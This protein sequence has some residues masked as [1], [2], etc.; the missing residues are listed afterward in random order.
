VTVRDYVLDRLALLLAFFVALAF[1]LLV[2]HLGVRPLRI[3]EVGY[4]ALLAVVAAAVILAVDYLRHT[5]FR[6]EVRR[7]LT[8][9]DHSAAALPRG[10]SREQRAIADLLAAVNARAAGELQRGR[11][12]SEH[13]RAFTDLWVHQMKTP[14][15]V[16]ELTAEQQL[17]RLGGGDVS[18]PATEA[19]RSVAEEVADL[20]NGL[21]LMLTTARLERFDLDLSPALTDLV[22]V[23]REAVNDLKRSW[24]RAGVYPR[25]DAPGTA[26]T[27]ETDPKWLRE[28]VRQLLTNAVK[29]S[30]PG[31]TVTITVAA[32]ATGARIDVTDTGI[33]IPPED[34]PRVFDRFYTGV[35]GRRG[36]ASTGMGLYLASEICRRLGHELRLESVLDHGTSASVTLTP[37]GLH[38]SVAP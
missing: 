27:A 22:V 1:L 4:I 31:G 21:D 24:I 13:H 38:R 20:S 6:T 19:W 15:A 12:A 30:R 10:A 7:R 11:S 16:L 36:K 23:A 37:R 17:A 34:V 9:R 32:V 28:V 35:N 29:Y 14:V 26:V 2:I 25:I 33:G 18:D 5:A 8:E 3:G